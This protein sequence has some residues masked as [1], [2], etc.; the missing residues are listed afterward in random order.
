MTL[1]RQPTAP[2]FYC[3]LALVACAPVPRANPDP[4]A[5]RCP[6]SSGKP[7]L[8]FELF[9]GR[10]MPR[11]GEV[12]DRDWDTFV[13]NVVTPALPGG[14][15]VYDA[16]GGWMSPV[17]GRTVHERTKVLMTALPASPGSVAAVNRVRNDYRRMFHQQAVGMT[18]TPTCGEF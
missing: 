16:A 13:A 2:A 12:T 11:S 10:S 9:L 1:P 8:E 5:A 7:L 18:V 4:I 15:T 14:F 17:S 6:V 3:A